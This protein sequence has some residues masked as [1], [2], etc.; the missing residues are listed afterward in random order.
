MSAATKTDRKFWA[1]TEYGERNHAVL[2]DPGRSLCGLR[3]RQWFTPR[4]GGETC[5]Y[6]GTFYGPKFPP[7]PGQPHHSADLPWCDYP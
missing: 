3:P 6:C 1:Q 4:P 5:D 2:G 7:P